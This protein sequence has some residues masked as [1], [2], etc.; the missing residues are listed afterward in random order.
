MNSQYRLPNTVGAA[1]AAKMAA[2]LLCFA[3]DFED[4]RAGEPDE[5]II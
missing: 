1:I 4:D 3:F 5:N 2:V